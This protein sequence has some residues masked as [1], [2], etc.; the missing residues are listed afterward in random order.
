M[1][2]IWK[3]NGICY[4]PWLEKADDLN[5]GAKSFIGFKVLLSTLNELNNLKN[6]NKYDPGFYLNPLGLKS[7]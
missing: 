4:A 5:Q 1:P 7:H 3:V 2:L 6:L